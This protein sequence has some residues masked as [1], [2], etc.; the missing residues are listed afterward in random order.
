[1]DDEQDMFIDKLEPVVSTP[2]VHE[3]D[4][5]SVDIKLIIENVKPYASQNF[6]TL[7]KPFVGSIEE[8]SR[9]K[10]PKMRNF[11]IQSKFQHFQAI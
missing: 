10:E 1:M 7:L 9:I 11:R 8:L 4:I 6:E 2:R 5:N 3:K